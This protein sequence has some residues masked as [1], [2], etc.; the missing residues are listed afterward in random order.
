V[1]PLARILNSG[2]IR[3]F[4]AWKDTPE[5]VQSLVGTIVKVVA[6]FAPLPEA[7]VA[8]ESWLHDPRFQAA[9]A[10]VITTGLCASA[11]ESHQEY[12]A[13]F[14]SIASHYPD[15]YDV[16]AVI[17]E[18][19]RIVHVPRIVGDLNARPDAYDD[20]L[21]RRVLQALVGNEDSPARLQLDE[22][23]EDSHQR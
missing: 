14:W 20:E 22:T 16:D 21:H 1:R 4:A 8:L 10:A 23:D 13:A 18:I 12:L 5:A 3:E 17:R 2:R 15:A 11:P 19:I 6:G 7:R 9:C